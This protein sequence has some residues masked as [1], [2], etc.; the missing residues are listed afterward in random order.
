[1]AK[2]PVQILFRAKCA[3]TMTEVEYA[4][5]HGAK[6]G[7]DSGISEHYQ[8]VYRVRSVDLNQPGRVVGNATKKVNAEVGAG[9]WQKK[10]G[11]IERERR[12]Y[13]NPG[14]VMPCLIL[15]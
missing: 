15:K 7:R 6:L 14:P 13:R 9:A 3:A 11:W 5:A 2:K 12:A 4:L 8:R 1:M 10:D